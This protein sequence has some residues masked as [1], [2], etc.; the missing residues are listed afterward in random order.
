MIAVLGSGCERRQASLGFWFEDVTF[1]SPVLGGRL[2]ADDLQAIQR[3]ARGEIAVAFRDLNVVLNDSPQ[4]RFRVRVTQTVTESRMRRHAV[5]A[6]ESRGVPWVGG[7]G[8]VN[9]TYYASGAIVFAPPRISRSDLVAAIGR[10]LG[11]GAVHEFAHQ[12]LA[13]VN[14]HDGRDRGSYEYYA[15]SREQQYYG[16]MHWDLAAPLLQRKYA[17]P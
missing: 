7:F 17:H 9:F 14:L 11:R 16:P 15:A 1:E 4:S 2:T 13:N 5:V 6:G 10:G 12:M 3:V 8:S